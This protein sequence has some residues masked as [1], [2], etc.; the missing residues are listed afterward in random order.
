MS[1]KKRAVLKKMQWMR[2]KDAIKVI[3]SHQPLTPY[4]KGDGT[5]EIVPSAISD[6]WDQLLLCEAIK[7]LFKSLK[8]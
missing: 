5:I 6:K 4:T 8:E 7:K 1:Q 2:T 3:N